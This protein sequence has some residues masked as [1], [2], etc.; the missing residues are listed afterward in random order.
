L[1]RGTNPNGTWSLFVIDDSLGQAGSFGSGAC[2]TFTL[3]SDLTISKS[4]T[5]N[6]NAGQTGA[7]YTLTVSNLGPADTIGQVSVSDTL[8]AG[9]TATALSGTGW[10]CDL[11]TLTCTRSDALASGNSYPPITLTVNVASNAPASVTNMVSVSGGGE[12]NTANNTATDPTTVIQ[13][14]SVTVN[15]SPAGRSFAVDGTTYTS[16]QTFSWLI[17][18]MHTLSTTSP[19]NGGSTRYVWESWSDGG[20]I[21]HTVTAAGAATYT[22]NFKTQHLLTTSVSP[23]GSGVIAP[24]TGYFDQG[25]SVQVTATANAGFTFVNFSGDLTGSTNP[26]SVVMSAPRSVVANFT[27]TPTTLN[28]L[29]TSKSGPTDAR[30]W[31]ITITNTGAGTAASA[32]ISSLVLTQTGGAACTPAIT[33]PAL[34]LITGNIAP[35]ASASGI[36]TINFTGCAANARFTAA[37]GYGANNG[38]IANTKTLY[39]QFR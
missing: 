24:A 31:T 3:P 38:A 9:L 13:T 35:G 5:G 39:N 11:A 18:S 19:Q 26:Q 4:H 36:I 21:S 29:I 10:I 30:A 27:G 8:P 22:A 12:L 6:F 23:A 37:I 33:G 20:A 2:L 32:Q 17:G 25:S 15:T 14:V 28:A 7:T 1:F 16:A 34:P